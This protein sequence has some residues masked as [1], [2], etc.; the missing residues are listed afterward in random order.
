MDTRAEIREFLTTRR[1]RVTAAEAGL[2]DHGPRRVPGLRREE[3][4]VLAG[5]SVPYYTRLER[6]DLSG[7]SEGV[8]EAL[9]G[10]LQLNDAERA[11]LF[12]LA[13]AAR[14]S[15]APKRRRA[16]KARIR[17]EIQW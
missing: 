10:A 1:A 9:S 2:P 17:P 15:G 13:R 5:V 4:A 16:P 6:G 3:V 8:L 11:H 7:V 12:D 14:P